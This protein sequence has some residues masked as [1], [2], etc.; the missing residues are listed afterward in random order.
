MFERGQAREQ[1]EERA[2]MVALYATAR[3]AAAAVAVNIGW[4]KHGTGWQPPAYLE[5]EDKPVLVGR[6]GQA[7]W[8]AVDL[9]NAN[10][11]R[12]N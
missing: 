5:P 12:P 2:R 7:L 1:R 8:D 10:L 3:D 9:F 6:S 11:G 4:L